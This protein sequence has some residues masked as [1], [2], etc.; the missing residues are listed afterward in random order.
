MSYL[1]DFLSE[2]H[3]RGVKL[4]VNGGKLRVEAPLQSLSDADRETLAEYK[5][6]IIAMLTIPKPE[7]CQVCGCPIYFAR[8]DGQVQCGN[9]LPLPPERIARRILVVDLPDGQQWSD[10]SEELRQ[11]QGRQREQRGNG[12]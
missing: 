3:E 12:R 10:Y 7:P 6:A 8:H 4:A 2:L 5:P 1:A 11:M 9:C